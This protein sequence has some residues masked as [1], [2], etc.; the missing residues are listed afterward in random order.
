MALRPDTGRRSS[1]LGRTKEP[2]GVGY[3]LFLDVV[4]AVYG[5]GR[6]GIDIV[7]ARYGL[8]SKEFTPPMVKG[9]FDELALS[10]PRRQLTVGIV[11][12]VSGG[13]VEPDGGFEV[14]MRAL[15]AVFFGLGSDGTVG[16]NKNSIK[17]IGEPTDLHAQGYFVDDS[18]NTGPRP[19]SPRL[20]PRLRSPATA[21]YP[22]HTTCR[23][24]Q[25][26]G[27][28][29]PIELRAD[30]SGGEPTRRRPT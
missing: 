28:P 24:Q 14:P 13:S 18:A 19:G 16:A 10:K 12:D 30:R 6:R 11:D 22:C 23:S 26:H 5:S 2:G 8:G 21:S 25:P 20:R 9:V 3:R 1:G 4:A 7:A 15:Q 27:D 29:S 17:I